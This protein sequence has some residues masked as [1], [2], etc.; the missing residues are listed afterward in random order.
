M[1]IGSEALQDEAE[2]LNAIYGEKTLELLT[3]S[4]EEIDAVL[5]L[6]DQPVSFRLSFPLDYPEVPPIVRGTISTGGSGKGEGERA[7]GLLL[8][9]LGQVYHP[10]S[11]CLYDLSEELRSRLAGHFND[12]AQN[13]TETAEDRSDTP[14]Q[15]AVPES[16]L[17]ADTASSIPPP[18]WTIAQP[19]TVN[20]STF[21]A[22]ALQVSSM[23]EVTE[24]VS[25][26]LSTNKKVASATHN[27]K[28]WRMRSEGATSGF[29]QDYDDD[30]ETAAG[31][32][33]LH[34][35]QLMDVSNVLVVVTRWY[36]G[37]KLGPDRFRIINNVGR[38]ALMAGGFGK[39]QKGKAKKGKK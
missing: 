2:A 10:G 1:T 31:G 23:S 29:V 18:Q 14:T 26:L 13:P 15:D 9:A 36:G 7:V 27:I 21:V 12:A 6:P 22:R 24:A 34:L 4:A 20:K 25:H 35:M 28:A 30:G 19:V 8:D 17:T 32:R 5:R 11:V 16:D 39:E 38:D 37:V 33:L 3:E